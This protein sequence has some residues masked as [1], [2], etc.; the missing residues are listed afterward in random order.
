[1]VKVV[2]VGASGY[3][4]AQLCRI[5]SR[6]EK[7]ELAALFVSENSLDKGKRI[8]D[9]YG[10]LNGICDKMILSEKQTLYFWQQIIR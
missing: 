7:L 10:E 8:S 2:V 6:H 3:A 1:M 5:I 9:L 4:G